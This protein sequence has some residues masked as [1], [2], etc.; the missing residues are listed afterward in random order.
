MRSGRLAV[1]EEER[2]DDGG[3]RVDRPDRDV[4]LAGN[5]GEGDADA[6]KAE[7]GDALQD[8]G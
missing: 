2:G 4:D 7:E 3:E 5:Q 8:A 1:L 6:E